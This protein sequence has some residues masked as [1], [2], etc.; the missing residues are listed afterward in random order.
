MTATRRGACVLTSYVVVELESP[1][2]ALQA[3]RTMDGYAFDKK[4]RFA[5]NRFSDIER[6]ASMDETYV[7]PP[8]EPYK[9]RVRT[10]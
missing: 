9:Q 4:H 8:E 2:A 10:R 5:V 1:D 7:E 3:I 6:L